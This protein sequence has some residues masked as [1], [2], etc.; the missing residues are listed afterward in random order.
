[1]LQPLH[2]KIDKAVMKICIDE[3]YDYILNTDE[4]AYIAI[5]PKHGKDITNKL[6]KELVI[7]K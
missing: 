2:E 5:N 1:M 4:R 6:M 7:E 3:G